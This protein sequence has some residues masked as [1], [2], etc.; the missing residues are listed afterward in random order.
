MPHPR[1]TTTSDPVRPNA[2]HSAS[3]TASG[4]PRAVPGVV[5]GRL[6]AETVTHA[7]QRAR[8]RCVR[9]SGSA[10][11]RDAPPLA[12]VCTVLATV[13]GFRHGQLVSSSRNRIRHRR[14]AGSRRRSRLLD[15]RIERRPRRRRHGRRRVPA[16]Q[17]SRRQG[18][19]R[20]RAVDRR[21]ALHDAVRLRR[22]TVRRALDG[23]AGA[24]EGRAG[25]LAHVGLHGQ[26]GR[27]PGQQALVDRVAG[28]RRSGGV[29]R[30]AGAAGLSG[31]R[32]HRG[33]GPVHAADRR[34]ATTRGS[35]AT[36]S[37]SPAKRTG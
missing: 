1:S 4:Y 8:C 26:P 11:G 9:A 16:A 14:R 3:M 35:A 5:V 23:T 10:S 15:R 19:D 24:G 31:R 27:R 33:Q 7:G 32:A 34:R 13:V 6:T 29:R 28:G 12:D 36:C 25:P 21:R 37:T 2:S 20:G 17:R 22:D 30:R 18:P